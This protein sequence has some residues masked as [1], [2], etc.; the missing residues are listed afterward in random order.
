LGNNLFMAETDSPPTLPATPPPM[1]EQELQQK[2]Q[3][4]T[5]SGMPMRERLRI[6]A[7]GAMIGCA[8]LTLYFGRRSALRGQEGAERTL[9]APSGATGGMPSAT[10]AATVSPG[11]A[12]IRVP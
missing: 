6:F 3:I 2:S 4:E 8:M 5:P 11:D 9:V 12:A 7:I 1:A 10:P